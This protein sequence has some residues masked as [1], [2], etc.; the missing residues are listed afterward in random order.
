MVQ[1]KAAPCHHTVCTKT[2]QKVMYATT[3][4][5]KTEQNID[6]ILRTDGHH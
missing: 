6:V 3:L 2:N 4:K 1:N 5:Q